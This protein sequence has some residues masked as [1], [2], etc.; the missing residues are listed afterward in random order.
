MTDV[1]VMSAVVNRVTLRVTKPPSD[2][3]R[4]VL[5]PRERDERHLI[6]EAQAAVARGRR[7]RERELLA[8]AVFCS[9]PTSNQYP[10]NTP[11]LCD[12]RDVTSA[13]ADLES[14]AFGHLLAGQNQPTV[15]GEPS[16][17]SA[18]CFSNLR[19]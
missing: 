14:G 9:R 1:L 4:T 6:V 15:A 5:D 16:T 18:A 19:S 3:V 8:A 17:A 11:I 7:V 2:Q 12:K 13:A 10:P